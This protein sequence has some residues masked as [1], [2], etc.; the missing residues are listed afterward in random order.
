MQGDRNTGTIPENVNDPEE[1]VMPQNA[2]AVRVT[3]YGGPEVLQLAD[4]EVGEPGP[5]EIRI[6]H[7]ACGLNYIDVYHRTGLYQNALPLI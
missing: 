5:G 2:R 4:V 1:T 6:R 7:H 3:A